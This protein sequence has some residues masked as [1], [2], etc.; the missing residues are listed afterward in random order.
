MSEAVNATPANTSTPIQNAMAALGGDKPETKVEEPKVETTE[1]KAETKPEDE[2]KA[3]RFAELSKKEQ[4]IR[5]KDLKMQA[6]LKAREEALTRR[7]AEI[8][9]SVKAELRRL[10][11]EKPLD[12]I[13]ELGTDY[14]SM[15]EHVLSEGKLTPE[16]VAKS[17]KEEIEAL[18]KQ[19]EDRDKAI[20]Q[21]EAQR[22]QEENERILRS[23]SA[24][25][26]ETVK[27]NP[28]KYPAVFES[29]GAPVIYHM[30]QQRYEETKGKHLLTIDEAAEILEK[31]LN[32]FVSRVNA[33]KNGSQPKKETTQP[34]SLNKPK[35][36]TNELTSS[37]PSMLPAAKEE[38]RI[39]RALAKLQ[40]T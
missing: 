24:N 12:A 7:E 1:V 8:K 21:K 23:F 4:R 6:D 22:K 13:K 3:R 36:I 31:D 34:Q 27:S 11:K 33:R 2:L 40:G 17:T 37:A 30:I 10:A 18:K 19:I 14:Q 25:I 9:E 16:I 39:K 5:Q 32:A 20:E 35:T 29:E 15:T 38:D 26:I 28:D